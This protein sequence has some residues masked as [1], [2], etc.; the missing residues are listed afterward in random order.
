[1]SIVKQ[2]VLILSLNCSSIIVDE[3]EVYV[4]ICENIYYDDFG[5]PYY[6]NSYEHYYCL[7]DKSYEVDVYEDYYI[8]YDY[9]EDCYYD[10]YWD[11]NTC[12][13]TFKDNFTIISLD[14]YE[15]VESGAIIFSVDEG[16][17]L[18]NSNG[19]INREYSEYE[20]YF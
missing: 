17:L 13:Y 11:E 10:E 2:V 20:I 15:P 5:E 19:S 4:C 16:V 3:G 9:N 18:N 12:S 8:G 1:M 6:Q 14:F 7:T